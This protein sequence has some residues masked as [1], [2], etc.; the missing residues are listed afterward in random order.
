[1][2]ITRIISLVLALILAFTLVSCGKKDDTTDDTGSENT[3]EVTAGADEDDNPS[4]AKEK[5][6][7]EIQLL[8]NGKTVDIVDTEIRNFVEKEFAVEEVD[9]DNYEFKDVSAKYNTSCMLVWRYKNMTATSAKV[10][11]TPNEDLSDPLMKEVENNTCDFP[12]LYTN[13]RYYWWVEAETED[14]TVKSDVATIDIADGPR[15]LK[16]SGISNFRDMGTWTNEDGKHMKEG[17]V[18]RCANPDEVKEAGLDFIL[19]TLGVRTQVDLRTPEE[20]KVA[21]Y[22]DTHIGAF[23]ET[24]EYINL[25]PAAQYASSH[26]STVLPE[27]LRV[28]A[29]PENYPIIFHCAGGADRTGTLALYLEGICGCDEITCVTDYEMTGGRYR[30]YPDSNGNPTFALMMEN[31]KAYGGDTFGECVK[32]VARTSL[33]LTEMEISNIY[34]MLM[35]D[36][37]VFK[38]DSLSSAKSTAGG[39]SFEI[40]LRESGGVEKV[41]IEGRNVEWNYEDGTLAIY[42]DYG[43]GTITFNDGEKLN[44]G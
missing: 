5:G 11:I 15:V 43:T 32:N 3:A 9:Y 6:E 40:D 16:V 30:G 28:F 31:I 42:T 38:K 24:V 44:F 34:N 33:G 41:T 2:K 25:T 29:D 8:M 17:L 35:T 27:E 18:F 22:N 4:K 36:S 13:T 14:G 19:N 20:G 37:G 10:Y 12:N 1:M 7:G 21:E 23:G 26:K 39:F